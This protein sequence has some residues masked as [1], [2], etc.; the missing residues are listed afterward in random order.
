[1]ITNPTSE[2]EATAGSMEV[3][4]LEVAGIPVPVSEL[5]NPSQIVK[6][7]EIVG[8]VLTTTV[9]EPEQISKPEVAVT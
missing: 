4:G 5:V 7:P 8:D 2:S 3:H 9:V 6:T 1:M